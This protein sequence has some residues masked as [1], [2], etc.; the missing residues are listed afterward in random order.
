[1]KRSKARI[2]IRLLTVAALALGLAFP[3]QLAGFLLMA[4]ALL[5]AVAVLFRHLGELT[6]LPDGHPKLKTLRLVT[7]FSVILL[8]ACT[9]VIVLTETGRLALSEREEMALAA[10][11]ECIV[12]LF[13]GNVAP[14]LP[15]S[16]HTG[17]RL[18]W[19]VADDETWI[20]AHRVLGYLSLPLVL[21]YVLGI[22]VVPSFPAFSVAIFLLW[23]GIP[24]GL[25]G[26][27]YCRKFYPR[28]N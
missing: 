24:A 10:C 17:L 4:A 22:P 20:V 13:G 26:L 25:S 19:T 8:I 11:I 14:K 2:W 18:P 27:F 7:A 23:I 21:V 3:G 15:R 12:M 16:A 9:V 28:R 1:M 5:G 6:D